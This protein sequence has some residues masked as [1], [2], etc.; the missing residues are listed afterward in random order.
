MEEAVYLT[1]SQMD[2]SLSQHSLI[3]RLLDQVGSAQKVASCI[4]EQEIAICAVRSADHLKSDLIPTL[5]NIEV[6]NKALTLVPELTNC[7]S[8]E[9]YVSIS[10]VK[11]VLSHMSIEALDES[12]DDYPPHQEY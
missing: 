3:C 7:M 4:M 2:H 6:L 12:D 11:P 9:I 1:K 10:T 8:G 5:H